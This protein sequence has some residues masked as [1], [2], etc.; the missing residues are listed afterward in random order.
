M[1]AVGSLILSILLFSACQQNSFKIE[2]TVEG[3]KDGD[4]ILLARDINMGLPTDT[5][6][7]GEGAFHYKGV[8]DSVVLALL[9]AQ[10]DPEIT[11][12]L[13]LDHGTIEV[14]LADEAGKTRIGGTAANEA[15][16]E[17]NYIAFRYGEQMQQLAK[18]IC[19][20]DHDASSGLLAKAQLERL[21][22]DLT[23]KIISLAERNIDN[24]FGFFIV[25][26]L[27]DENFSDEHRL[28]LIEK[29]PEKFRQRSEIIAIKKGT[30]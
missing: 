24:E 13:F 4:T 28:Q 9:Y 16:Q 20:Q 6:I 5:M 2:G 15:L 26:N 29:M 12:T 30:K 8:S 18:T 1:K 11:T 25:V 10:K 14:T 27:E 23:Q 22:S 19:S 21:K 3:L 7:V 17:A